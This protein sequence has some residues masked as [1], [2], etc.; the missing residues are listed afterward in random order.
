MMMFR[1]ATGPS[2]DL[3]DK[4]DNELRVSGLA[5]GAKPNVSV[6]CKLHAEGVPWTESWPS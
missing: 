2:Q 4:V 3:A 5:R 1:Q 6:E